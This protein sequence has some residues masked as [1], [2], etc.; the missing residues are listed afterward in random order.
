M[1]TAKTKVVAAAAPE[2]AAA[3]VAHPALR[4]LPLGEDRDG[5]LFWKLQTGTLFTGASSPHVVGGFVC[6]GFSALDVPL[7]QVE[8]DLQPWKYAPGTDS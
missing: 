4:T 3:A 1:E 8:T 5:R 6:I 2:V 7:K